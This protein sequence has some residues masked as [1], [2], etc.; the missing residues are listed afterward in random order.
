MKKIAVFLFILGF[1]VNVYA[2]KYTKR[3]LYTPE[4]IVGANAGLNY[5]MGEDVGKY[6]SDMSTVPLGYTGRVLVGYNFSPQSGIR[7]MLG[8]GD[9]NS[10][11]TVS[12]DT[13]NFSA[14]TLSADY[15]LNL[16][17]T[18]GV[19]SAINRMNVS[20]FAG[21]G[22]SYREAIVSPITDKIISD[23]FISPLFRLGMILDIRINRSLDFNI[24]GDLNILRDPYNGRP[25]Y[26]VN[27]VTSLYSSVGTP[28]DILPNLTVGFIYKIPTEKM[29]LKTVRAY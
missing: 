24:I 17:N 18:F 14:F 26:K 20:A 22:V 9:F 1:A 27:G 16:N 10:P 8:F 19:Y 4:L 21:L 3:I 13:L 28:I 12:K 23:A 6:L 11:H 25:G 15:V 5:F 29:A 7:T 2:Q